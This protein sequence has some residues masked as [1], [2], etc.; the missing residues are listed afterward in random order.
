MI[1]FSS[2][3][4][5][6]FAKSVSKGDPIETPSICLYILALNVNA[7]FV[8]PSFNKFFSIHFLKLAITNFSLQT[9]FRILSIVFANGALVNNGITSKLTN[10]LPESNNCFG[11][12]WVLLAASKEA[13]TVKSSRMVTY[14]IQNDYN[15][16]NYIRNIECLFS[17]KTKFQVLDKDL[18]L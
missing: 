18:V 4:L 17:D 15:K 1:S 8:H 7:V 14:K 2:S 11:I 6:I 13:F 5:R 9:R 10:F 16:D 12:S 3:V